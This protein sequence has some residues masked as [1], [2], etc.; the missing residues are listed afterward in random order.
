MTLIFTL[1]LKVWEVPWSGQRSA[2]VQTRAEGVE[3]IMRGWAGMKL[4]K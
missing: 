1:V 4:E 3:L 2:E